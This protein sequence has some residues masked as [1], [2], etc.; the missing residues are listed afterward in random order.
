MLDIQT[1]IFV[2]S[3]VPSIVLQCVVELMFPH[4]FYSAICPPPRLD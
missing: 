3:A 4:S 1:K 2:M